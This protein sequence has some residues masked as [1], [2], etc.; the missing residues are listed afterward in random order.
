MSQ[1]QARKA[2]KAQGSFYKPALEG[3]PLYARRGFY[4]APAAKQERMMRDRGIE[5]TYNQPA[6]PTKENTD[7]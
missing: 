3:T 7:D 2:R 1:K 4:L 6:T 5:V